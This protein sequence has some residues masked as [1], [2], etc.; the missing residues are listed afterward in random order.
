M[1]IVLPEVDHLAARLIHHIRVSY[2]P[3]VGNLPIEGRGTGSHLVNRQFRKKLPN[4]GQRLANA[5]AGNAPANGKQPLGKSVHF[6]W[7][8]RSVR[9]QPHS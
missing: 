8:D 7:D 1:Q 2:I 6:V 9:V 5:F 3:F 4:R